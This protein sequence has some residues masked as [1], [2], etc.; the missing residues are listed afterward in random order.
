[1]ITYRLTP[2]SDGLADLANATAAQH[3]TEIEAERDLRKRQRKTR[4]EPATCPKKAS[5]PVKGGRL[6]DSMSGTY[7]KPLIETNL[8]VCR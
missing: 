3:R 7:P 1:V 6:A 8:P 4:N 2:F 5:L